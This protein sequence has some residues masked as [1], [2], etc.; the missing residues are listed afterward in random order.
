MDTKAILNEVANKVHT[1]RLHWIKAHVGFDGN[2]L[3][4]EYAKEG[5]WHMAQ[6]KVRVTHLSEHFLQY[7][8]YSTIKQ[9]WDVFI[10]VRNVAYPFF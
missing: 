7:G 3:V 1:L 10:A 6:L 5:A 8:L 2:E 9:I 4:D